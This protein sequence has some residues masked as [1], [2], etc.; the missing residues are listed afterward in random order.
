VSVDCADLVAARHLLA[1]GG[2]IG[3]REMGPD[4]EGTVREVFAGL[5]PRSRER[6]FL[7]PKPRLTG[8]DLRQLA[9]VDGVDHVALVAMHEDQA[10]G[11]AR[12]VRDPGDPETADAAIA[13]V[14][15]WQRRGVGTALVSAL[16]ERGREAGVRRFGVTV[17]RDNDGALR[18]LH[19]AR[20]E[21]DRLA[22]DGDTIELAVSPL[23]SPQ[24][25][26]R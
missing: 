4:E 12:F 26:L 15:A 17:L 2:I 23:G 7:A 10:I 6:R 11:V 18:L 21:V 13:V 9:A 1:D 16:L 8:P 3:V 20:V 19:R 25:S 14:D 22:I 5:G 24:G